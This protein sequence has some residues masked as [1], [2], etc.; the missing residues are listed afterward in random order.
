MVQQADSLVPVCYLCLTLSLFSPMPLLP[1]RHGRVLRPY[2][3]ITMAEV[4]PSRMAQLSTA[5]PGA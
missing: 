5:C 1:C 4:K 3:G 2:V